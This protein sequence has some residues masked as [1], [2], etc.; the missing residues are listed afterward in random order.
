MLKMLLLAGL[1]VLLPC[2]AVAQEA[3]KFEVFGGYSYLRANPK[4]GFIGSNAHGWTA[5]AAWNWN[6]WLG[7]KGE[8]TGTYC[9]SGN[10]EKKHDFLGGPQINF[11]R[12]KTN[13]F[14]HGLVGIS[15][16]DAPAFSDTVL[17][18]VGG[19]GVDIRLNDRFS[20]RVAQVDYL[21]TNYA[22]TWQH[23]FRYSGGVVIKFGKK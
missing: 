7:V 4:G 6:K 16:G 23:H 17:A 19:G 1:L 5:S 18:W 8:V 14:V 21:G 3:P 11:R 20:L 22:N 12:N 13:F 10:G 15:R 2:A 9:C